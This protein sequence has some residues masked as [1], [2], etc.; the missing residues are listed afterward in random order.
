[1]ET[2]LCAGGGLFYDTGTTLSAE[3]YYGVGTT[4]FGK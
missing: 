1:M 2:V 4:G 3:G